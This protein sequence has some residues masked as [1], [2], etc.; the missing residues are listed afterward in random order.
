MKW[1]LRQSG[2][3]IPSPI[4][5]NP[6]TIAQKSEKFDRQILQSGVREPSLIWANERPKAK[7]A[8]GEQGF[9]PTPPNLLVT[10]KING[11]N[12]SQKRVIA[13][14]YILFDN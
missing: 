2:V 3:T 8:A 11:K 13:K 12:P 1:Q 14:K 9:C 7:T 4:S 10:K 6:G 5:T